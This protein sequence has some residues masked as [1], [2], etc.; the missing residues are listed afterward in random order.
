MDA[1]EVEGRL[2]HIEQRIAVLLLPLLTQHQQLTDGRVHGLQGVAAQTRIGGVA[3]LAEDVDALHQH[4]F[5]QADR[6]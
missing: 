4:T 5:M 1:A 2:R 3:A 6:L